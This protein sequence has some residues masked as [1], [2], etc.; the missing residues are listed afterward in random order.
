MST[1]QI[2]PIDKGYRLKLRVS[3]LLILLSFLIG[4]TIFTSFEFSKNRA[5]FQEYL[6]TVVSLA[7]IIF[8][9]SPAFYVFTY[10]SPQISGKLIAR[11]FRIYVDRYF[12]YSAIYST[13][14]IGTCLFGLIP[15]Y[16]SENTPLIR[17]LTITLT[18][19]SVAMLTLSLY[20]SFL[21]GRSVYVAIVKF[22]V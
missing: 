1:A 5:V 9:F 17:N 22:I 7:A 14:L 18:S 21:L 19:L 13:L 12:K 6:K 20:W 8:A 2:S 10:S 11:N 3:W 4:L 16:I 15:A